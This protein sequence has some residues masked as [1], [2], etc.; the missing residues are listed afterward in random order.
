MASRRGTVSRRGFVKAAGAAMG[1][2]GMFSYLG[3]SIQERV[4]GTLL[5][6]SKIVTDGRISHDFSYTI[7]FWFGAAC[8]SVALSCLV[9]RARPS[10]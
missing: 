9:W 6:S 4:S 3:A 1:V 2:V 8:V 10:D 5:E 7:A